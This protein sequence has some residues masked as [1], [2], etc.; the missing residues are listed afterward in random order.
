[1]G[2][3]FQRRV[4]KCSLCGAVL[5]E[6]DDYCPACLGERVCSRVFHIAGPIARLIAIVG[7]LAGISAS[8]W[9]ADRERAEREEEIRLEQER[10][11]QRP[12]PPPPAPD[13][14]EKWIHTPTR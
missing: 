1:M 14:F 10:Q 13:P 3:I 12:P 11:R 2:G 8:V 5:R 9:M 4:V 7:L 6:C